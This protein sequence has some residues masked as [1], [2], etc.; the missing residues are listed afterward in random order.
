MTVDDSFCSAPV[1]IPLAQQLGLTEVTDRDNGF[2]IMT[3][4]SQIPVPRIH[5]AKSRHA[6]K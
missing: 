6:A 3:S 4:G 1:C 5:N 2:I